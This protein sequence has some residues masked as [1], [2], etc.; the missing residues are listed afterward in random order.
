MSSDS[1]GGGWV[2]ERAGTL[3]SGV[4][5]CTISANDLLYR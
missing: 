4:E 3:E 2:K 5:M 1:C